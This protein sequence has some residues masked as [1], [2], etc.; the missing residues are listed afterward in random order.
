MIKH[1]LSNFANK[2][3]FVLQIEEPPITKSRALLLE[4]LQ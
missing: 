3:L 1:V 4:I 2:L